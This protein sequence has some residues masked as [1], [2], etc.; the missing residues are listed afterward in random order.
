MN[1]PLPPPP[2]TPPVVAPLLTARGGNKERSVEE[3]DASPPKPP[4]TYP[5][6]PPSPPA[7]SSPVS[8]AALGRVATTARFVRLALLL[9]LLLLPNEPVVMVD[10]APT[11]GLLPIHGGLTWALSVSKCSRLAV[12]LTIS[13]SKNV[14]WLSTYRIERYVRTD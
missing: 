8:L 2:P 7:L 6:P 14:C 13:R 5:P 12:Y 3:D 9:L 4:N 1:R 11:A 10:N